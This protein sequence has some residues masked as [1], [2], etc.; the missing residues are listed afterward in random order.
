MEISL[1]V[2]TALMYDWWF[3]VDIGSWPGDAR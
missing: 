3:G 2:W 1:H